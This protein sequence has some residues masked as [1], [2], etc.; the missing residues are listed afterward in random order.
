MID[1]ENYD[2]NNVFA[3]ILKKET[4]LRKFIEIKNK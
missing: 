1:I 2:E 3:K 4:L